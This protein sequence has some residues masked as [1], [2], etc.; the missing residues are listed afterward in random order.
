M[1]GRAVGVEEK[2]EPYPSLKGVGNF[3]VPREP[4]CPCLQSG[5]GGHTLTAL[6][7]ESM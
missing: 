3:E 6:W 1:G 4:Q 5:P 2:E 7:E